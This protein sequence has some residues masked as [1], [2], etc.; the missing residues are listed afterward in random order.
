MVLAPYSIILAPY[1]IMLGPYS[2]VLHLAGSPAQSVE[3]V[4][5]LHSVER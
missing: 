4:A 3:H 2:M 1:S 5:Q